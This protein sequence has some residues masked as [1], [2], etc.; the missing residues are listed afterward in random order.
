MT[1]STV[2]TWT[3]QADQRAYDPA[4]KYRANEL[5]LD[6]YGEGSI[7]QQTIDNISGNRVR[8]DGRAGAGI[9]LNY[10]F[11]RYVGLSG[12]AYTENTHGS[13][14][15]DAG[16]NVVLRLP[17]GNSGVAPYIFGGGGHQ[18]DPVKQTYYDAGA[19]IEFRI[20]H[21]WGFFVDGRYVF[22]QDTD[23]FGVGRAGLRLSF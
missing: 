2:A 5:S 8:Q 7:N 10:F 11:T 9:G 20:T 3:A 13:Y 4:D 22:A 21:N 23:N 15:D 14:V 19:G 1:A 12:D 16:G 18:F 6:L 17:L